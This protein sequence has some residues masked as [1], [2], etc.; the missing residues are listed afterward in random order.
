VDDDA[1]LPLNLIPLPKSVTV[2]TGHLH[3]TRTTRI[4][5]PAEITSVAQQLA[6][7]LQRSTGLPLAVVA[8]PER[9]G[10]IVLELDSQLDAL[11]S[12]GYEL[13]VGEDRARIR[14]QAPAGLFY[15]TVTLRQLL[16]PK[17]EA[18]AAVSDETWRLPRVAIEDTPRFEWRGLSFDVARHFFGVDDIKRVIDLAAYHKLNRLHVHLTDDQGWRIEIQSWPRLA[19]YGGSS[20][21]GGGPGGYYTR[22]D[23]TNIVEYAAQ[24]FITVIPE[25]DMPGHT[26]AALASY[27]EL[28]ADGTPPPLYTGTEVGL[29]SLWLGAEITLSFVDDVLREVAELTPGPYLHVGGDEAA[30]TS[31]AAYNAFMASVDAIVRKYGKRLIGWCEAGEA[32]L[33]TSALLQHWHTDCAG[34][35]RGAERGNKIIL[36]EANYAYLDMKYT[37]SSP[38]GHTWAGFIEVQKAYEW[39]PVVSGVAETAIFG[40]EAALW[41]EFVE[42]RDQADYMMFPRLAGH[43]E[44]G[45]SNATGR[46]FSEYRVRLAH[47]GKRLEALG[48]SFYRSSQVDWQ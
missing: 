48:V 26:N 31:A 12:E 19:T 14:A 28:N 17:I 40:I 4:V 13:Q 5:A 20:L 10:D 32:E 33:A 8:P 37:E 43:A 46:A 41:T 30:G 15:G 23:Y 36:S 3:L 2:G 18:T 24:R 34:T 47:H 27:A 7:I 35:I 16:P 44:I 42:T 25:I 22:A 21:V 9:R 29:S 6:I 11:G 1:A 38:I 39:T 45:W